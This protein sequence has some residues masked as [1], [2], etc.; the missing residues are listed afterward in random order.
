MK[1]LD[2]ETSTNILVAGERD[3]QTDALLHVGDGD[4]DNVF[5]S[6]YHDELTQQLVNIIQHQ[7]FPT[8]YLIRIY[9]IFVSFKMFVDKILKIM[10]Y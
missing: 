7:A 9:A 8:Y 10:I 3:K 1:R 4:Y 5:T 6:N 2:N